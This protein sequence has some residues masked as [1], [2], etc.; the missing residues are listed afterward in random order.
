MSNV[1]I[2]SVVAQKLF[3]QDRSAQA[4]LPKVDDIPAKS[5]RTYLDDFGEHGIPFI[6]WH[7]DS[8]M[9]GSYLLFA[10]LI[11]VTANS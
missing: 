1:W 4:S 3:W 5:L 8:Y 7:V 6:P 2:W 11:G 10:F 9:M